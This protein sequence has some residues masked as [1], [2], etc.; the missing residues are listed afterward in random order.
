[1]KKGFTLIEL[2][3]ASLLLGLLVSILTTVFSQSS[4]AWSTGVA[5]VVDLDETRRDMAELQVSADALLGRNGLSIQGVFS[6][7]GNDLNDRACSSSRIGNVG[8]GVDICNP[9]TW[10]EISVGGAKSETGRGALGDGKGY[11][12]GV[13]SAGPDRRFDTWDDITTWPAD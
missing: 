3:V 12:V 4:I 2:L 11:V 1:M 7:M 10:S 5:G 8:G 13:T 9:S 6:G